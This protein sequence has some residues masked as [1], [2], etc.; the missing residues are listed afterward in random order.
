MESRHKFDRF[1]LVLVVIFDGQI[2]I[3]HSFQQTS[4][5]CPVL[6]G[7]PFP[8]GRNPAGPWPSKVSL[9]L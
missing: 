5:R 6:R 4:S 7:D 1:L 2:H 3:I 8:A 9:A